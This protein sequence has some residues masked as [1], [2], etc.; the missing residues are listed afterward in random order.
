MVLMNIFAGKEWR[1]RHRKRTFAHSG[2]RKEWDEQR[3]Y[4]LYM[5]PCVKQLAGEKL[6]Y[7]SGNPPRH[8]MTT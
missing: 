4:M 8:A 7:N 3:N 5:L 6:L 1:C 2:G